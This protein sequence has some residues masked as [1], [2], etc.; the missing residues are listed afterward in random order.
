M[1]TPTATTNPLGLNIAWTNAPQTNAGSYPVTAT[2]N[3]ANYQGSGS[4]T[5][6]INPSPGSTPPSAAIT[7]PTSGSS[8]TVKSLVNIQANVTQGTYAIARVD[9]LVN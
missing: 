2:V 4:G 6:T 7:S 3:N 9:F 1:L 5:F 8:V